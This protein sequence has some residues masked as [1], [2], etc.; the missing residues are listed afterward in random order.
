MKIEKVLRY[1]NYTLIYDKSC[2]SAR[3]KKIFVDPIVRMETQLHTQANHKK[4]ILYP[5]LCTEFI[6]KHSQKLVLC[7]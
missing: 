3:A 2:F 7:K 4:A 1:Q 5:C 6:D